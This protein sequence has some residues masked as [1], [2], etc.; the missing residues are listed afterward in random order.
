M[1]AY[2]CYRIFNMM[3][4]CIAQKQVF[5]AAKFLPVWVMYLAG[6][7]GMGG[8]AIRTLQYGILPALRSFREPTETDETTMKE[9]GN[10]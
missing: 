4:L 8:T 7:L 3:L 6:V 5:S 10:D 1:A 2:L 9:G